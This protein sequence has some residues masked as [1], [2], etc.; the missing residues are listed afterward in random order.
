[1]NKKQR[2][3]LTR[4]FAFYSSVP[5]LFSAIFLVLAI[6]SEKPII[7]TEQT[8]VLTNTISAIK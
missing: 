7:N 5:L 8:S 3:D 2:D 1:M 4:L 6:S